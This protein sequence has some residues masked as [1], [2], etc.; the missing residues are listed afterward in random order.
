MF[1][2]AVAQSTSEPTRFLVDSVALIRRFSRIDAHT[3]PETAAIYAGMVA[4]FSFG[5]LSFGISRRFLEVADRLAESGAVDERV[6]Y[7]RTLHFLHHLLEGDWTESHSIEDSAVEE[8]VEQGRFWEASTY[9]N[10]DG[11][12]R[13]YQGRFEEAQDRIDRLGLIADTYGHDLAASA[14]KALTAYLYVERRE[15]RSASRVLETYYD[16]HAEVSFNLLA[17][18]TRSKVECLQ[19]NLDEAR[20]I[21]MRAE[22]LLAEAGRVPPYHAG[23]VHLSR[24][25]VSILGHSRLIGSQ[26]SGRELRRQ[27]RAMRSARSAALSSAGKVAFRRPET[28]R[29]YGEELWLRGLEEAAIRQWQ[30]AYECCEQLGAEPER[31]RVLASASRALERRTDL[32]L[33]GRDGSTCREEAV[34]I[35]DRLE[36]AFDLAQVADEG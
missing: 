10:L 2:R 3:V 15:F 18:G 27:A 20:R 23:I 32:R 30:I 9:L 34:A 24:Y 13:I 8:G 5:G 28:L 1:R 31:G 6:L 11:V 22:S 25:M 21:V 16:E 12:R 26:A 7:F 19:G 35:F 36:L 33:G 29:L 17:L 14:R 4:I